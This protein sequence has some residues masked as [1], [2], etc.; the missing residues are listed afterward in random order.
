[1]RRGCRCSPTPKIPCGSSS[2][3]RA[4]TG[5]RSG[6]CGALSFRGARSPAAW[7][8]ARSGAATTAANGSTR[9][10]S[11]IADGQDNDSRPLVVVLDADDVVFAEIAAGL[12]FDQ[13]ERD[14]AGVF[15]PVS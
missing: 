1:M 4:P 9:S 3:G 8:A 15:Q 11:N 14:L 6:T 13:L 7:S 5:Q 12:D 2:C 10:S